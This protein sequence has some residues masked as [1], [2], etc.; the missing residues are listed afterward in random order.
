MYSDYEIILPETIKKN[1][2]ENYPI[3]IYTFLDIVKKKSILL[4]LCIFLIYIFEKTYGHFIKFNIYVGFILILIV[5][6]LFLL[7]YHFI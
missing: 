2:L 5:F 4:T 7:A 3:M 1:S 6:T